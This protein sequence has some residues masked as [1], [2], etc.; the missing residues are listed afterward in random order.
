MISTC[1]KEMQR[2][3][4]LNAENNKWSTTKA[5]PETATYYHHQIN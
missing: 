1:T 2:F 5:K 4:A 3:V